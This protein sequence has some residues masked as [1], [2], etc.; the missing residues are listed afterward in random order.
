MAWRE[1]LRDELATNRSDLLQSRRIK[2]SENIPDDF[3]SLKIVRLYA[4]PLTS[5][6][7]SAVGLPNDLFLESSPLLVLPD[8]TALAGLL[9]DMFRH[10]SFQEIF[11][12]FRDSVL[13]GHF[14][15]QLIDV[16]AR[17]MNALFYI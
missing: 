16:R 4:K 10:W 13:P 8:A 7:R 17:F 6:S 12:K 11:N 3:P 9:C 14:T 5:A 2:C 1:R 15:R